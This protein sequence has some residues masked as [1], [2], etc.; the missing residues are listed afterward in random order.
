MSVTGVFSPGYPCE[1]PLKQKLGWQGCLGGWWEVR[2][3]PWKWSVPS[4]LWWLRCGACGK[5]LVSAGANKRHNGPFTGAGRIIP[6]SR[7]QSHLGLPL[8]QSRPL[9]ATWQPA[10]TISTIVEIGNLVLSVFHLWRPQRQA[11]WQ[12]KARSHFTHFLFWRRSLNLSNTQQH[13]RTTL[14]SALPKK[15][16]WHWKMK[17]QKYAKATGNFSELIIYLL[18]S[19]TV[20]QLCAAD[21]HKWWWSIYLQRYL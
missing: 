1:L 9:W 4:Q 20:L 7:N 13:K 10:V 15:F 21:C 5:W 6:L 14:E 16:P 12:R 3:G 17:R 19:E 2:S 8:H 11:G 18:V